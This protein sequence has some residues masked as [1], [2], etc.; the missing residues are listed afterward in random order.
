MRHAL[1]EALQ[2]YE[3]AVILVSH[4][5]HL[6]RITCDGLL[7]VDEGAVAPFDG[8]LDDYPNWISQRAS[9]RR[10]ASDP[11]PS[12]LG[13]LP[14]QAATSAAA[15]K[16]DLR[17]REAEERARL[18]PLRRDLQRL[19]QQL[20]TLSEQREQLD[21]ELAVPALYEPEAK[22]RLLALMEDKRRI[23]TEAR[24]YRAGMACGWRRA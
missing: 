15:S 2:E 16:K 17:R 24:R 4:D 6:L 10:Q 18:Q 21:Q 13:D 7:L 3:G 19:E 23:D 22:P 8:D 14:T 11:S 12:H 5:R 9:Q 20:E 1:S